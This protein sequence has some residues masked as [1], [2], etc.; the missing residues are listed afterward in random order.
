MSKSVI[1]T[2][3]V[4][5][6]NPDDRILGFSADKKTERYLKYR[7]S[8]AE[9]MKKNQLCAIE[10][11]LASDT[12][13]LSNIQRQ[14]YENLYQSTEEMT[15]GEF[16]DSITEGMY[17][18]EETGDAYSDVNPQ[19]KF[20]HERC[21]QDRLSKTG[22]EAEFSNPFI[23]KDGSKSYSARVCDI[24]WDKVHMAN[25]DIYKAAWELCVD[26]RDPQGELEERIKK[27]MENR[28]TYF[29]NFRDKDEYIR[30]SCSF[31]C[32]GVVVDYS[33]YEE[34]DY[35][36]SDKKW[37]ANFYDTYIKDLPTDTLLTIYEV[38]SLED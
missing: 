10:S 25:T 15:A 21:Y 7:H 20:K 28:I 8:S 11:I 5:G 3:L 34:V 24:D 23:L 6:D 17:I 36:T 32:Y 37:V 16:F 22:E 9:D 14:V 1:R 2:V 33:V 4:I 19:A 18:D 31:W 12:I 35:K 13:K 27:N 38:R 29:T 26:G 30:H